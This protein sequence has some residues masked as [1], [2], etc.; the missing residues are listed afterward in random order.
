MKQR[1]PRKQKKAIKTRLRKEA[2]KNGDK[3]TKK[4]LRM[5]AADIKA[6]AE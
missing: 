6:L 4:Q 5:T 3:L 1:I 2:E